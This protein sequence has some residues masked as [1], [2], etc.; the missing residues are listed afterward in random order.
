MI[1]AGLVSPPDPRVVDGSDPAASERALAAVRGLLAS[2]PGL[3]FVVGMGTEDLAYSQGDSGR[4]PGLEAPVALGARVC[5]GQPV[6]PT[7]VAIGAWLLREAGWTGDVQGYGIAP[8]GDPG[9]LAHYAD[10]IGALDD[11]VALLVVA[12]ADDAAVSLVP[13]AQRGSN[14]P[15]TSS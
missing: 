3:V 1:V 10:D 6:L 9:R 7:G 4:V 14:A 11:R 8:D 12:D 15:F 13:Q 2:R 5:V